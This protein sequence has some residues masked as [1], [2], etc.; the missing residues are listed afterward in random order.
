MIIQGITLSDYFCNRNSKSWVYR[1]DILSAHNSINTALDELLRTLFALNNEL[2]PSVK[3]KIFLSQYLK[4]L[5][6]KFVGSLNEILL[7][8]DFSVEELQRCRK[9]LNFLWKQI[10]PKVEDEVR[11]KFNEFAKSV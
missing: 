2:I 8:K 5:P 9:A 11:M 1:D 10:L 3:W 7:L 4:W 6:N